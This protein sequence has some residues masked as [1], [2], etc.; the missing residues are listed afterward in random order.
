MLI[1]VNYD[2][3]ADEIWMN[4][5]WFYDTVYVV[6]VLNKRLR[7]TTL[8]NGWLPSPRILRFLVQERSNIVGNSTFAAEAEQV[9]KS[10][11]GALINEDY[12]YCRWFWKISEHLRT[13]RTCGIK[14]GF[15]NSYKHLYASK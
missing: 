10:M 14:S 13:L 1:C 7:K 4:G 12:L 8:G 15:L 6:L 3:I 9:F 5:D 2:V 11:F